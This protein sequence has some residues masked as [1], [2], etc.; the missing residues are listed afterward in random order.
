MILRYL[1]IYKFRLGYFFKESHIRVYSIWSCAFL[2]LRSSEC[3]VHENSTCFVQESFNAT[4]IFL[5]LH[6]FLLD[7]FQEVRVGPIKSKFPCVYD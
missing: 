6:H 2:D 1:Q 7:V 4:A 5:Q 3:T